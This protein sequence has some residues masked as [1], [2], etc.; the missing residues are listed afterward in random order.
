MCVKYEMEETTVVLE[1]TEE[2]VG[3]MVLKEMSPAAYQEVSYAYVENT[4]DNDV[5]VIVAPPPPL[6]PSPPPLEGPDE[7][8]REEGEEEEMEEEEE[9][10]EHE[11][12]GEKESSLDSPVKKKQRVAVTTK[13]GP[14]DLDNSVSK[15]KGC[16]SG[17]TLRSD[18]TGY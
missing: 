18:I 9:D 13:P 7:E 14:V 6:P 1:G 5:Q 3:V 8:E 16:T 11:E 17:R 15:S 10:T 4:T 2:P 12:A